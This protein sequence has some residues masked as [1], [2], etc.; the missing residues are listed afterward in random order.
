MKLT[1]PQMMT[2]AASARGPSNIILQTL[3]FF[4]V[5]VVSAIVQMIFIF[6]LMFLSIIAEITPYTD[7]TEVDG[8][9]NEL[10]FSNEYLL[11]MLFSTFLSAAMV[12]VYCLCIERRSLGS[13][14]V[15]KKSAFG[16]YFA[17]LGVGFGL[18]ALCF[19]LCAVFDGLRIESVKY[20]I[21]YGIFALFFLGFVFQGAQEEFLCRGYFMNTLGGKHSVYVA[22][23][24]SSVA[25]SLLHLMNEGVSVLGLVNIALYGVLMGF[26]MICFDNI[27]GA[28]GIHTMWNFAQGCIFG[29]LVS[30]QRIGDPIVH[31][32]INENM[33]LL[34][35]GDFGIEGGIACTAVLLLGIAAL[36]FYLK[37]K[38]SR[39][40]AHEKNEIRSVEE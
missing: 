23:A 39:Q 17:G 14:G 30:G 22:V 18:F 21:N 3:I 28:C 25:F 13:M 33:T 11:V 35:G 7:V 34:N 26:Y 37:A 4:A 36:L 27:W 8:L 5:F 9:V 10:I 20:D 19:F 2:E 24:V 29:V 38:E 32:V 16:H 40:T 1:K 31:P 6:P 12:F 15:R